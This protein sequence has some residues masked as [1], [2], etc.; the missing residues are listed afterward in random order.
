MRLQYMAQNSSF[1]D[2]TDGK[3]IKARTNA[4]P[5][6]SFPDKAKNPLPIISSYFEADF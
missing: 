1:P 3:A 6:N 5:Q 2:T 4:H